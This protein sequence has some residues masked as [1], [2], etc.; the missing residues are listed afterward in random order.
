M[1]KSF[2]AVLCAALLVFA[3]S[4]SSSATLIG[5][6][7]NIGNYLNSQPD[8][9]AGPVTIG[10]GIDWVYV[11]SMNNTFYTLDIEDYTADVDFIRAA[12]YFN[13]AYSF[14]GLKITGF[15]STLNGVT[16]T[17]NLTGWDSDTMMEFGADYVTFNFTGLVA[18][19]SDTFSAALDFGQIIQGGETAVETGGNTMA[20]PIPA[21]IL[22]LGTGLVGLAGFR[23]RIKK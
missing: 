15:D 5:D 20:N 7:V 4:G 17:T 6:T 9:N 8:A 1:R 18:Y 21:P 2:F 23:R 14:N 16:V 13:N 11:D 12:T 10:S 3:F 22:L 19:N